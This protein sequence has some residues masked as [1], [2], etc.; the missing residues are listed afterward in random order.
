VEK[1]KLQPDAPNMIYVTHHT[2]EILPIFAHTILIR[3]GE[4]FKQGKTQDVLSSE[5]LS[6]F[7]ETPVD[8]RWHNDCAWLSVDRA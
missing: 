8:V 4:V 2:E 7:F 1:L 5:H 3:R 6:D